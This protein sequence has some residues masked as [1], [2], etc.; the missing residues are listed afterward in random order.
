MKILLIILHYLQ[1]IP[2]NSVIYGNKKEEVIGGEAEV[3]HPFIFFVGYLVLCYVSIAS[4][5]FSGCTFQRVNY[6]AHSRIS[7]VRCF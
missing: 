5:G 4:D 3:K 2:R 7:T 1:F 6:K